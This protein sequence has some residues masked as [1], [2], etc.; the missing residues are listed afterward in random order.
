MESNDEAD[1]T[2]SAHLV[3]MVVRTLRHEVGDLLQSVYSAV[4][5]L[6]ERLPKGQSLERTI[7]ADLRG[8]AEMCKNELDATHDLVCPVSLNLDWVELSEV[9]AGI[10]AAFALRFPGLQIVCHAPRPVKVWADG[11]RLQQA[12]TLLMMAFCQAAHAKVEIRVVV[13]STHAAVEW[14]FSHDGPAATDEQL[15]WLAAPFSTTRQARF[16]LG[17]GL[18]RRIVELQGG[19]VTTAEVPEGGFRLILRLPSA[20]AVNTRENRD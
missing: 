19:C 12:G 5:L 9:A 10:A 1:R 15:S 16:G 3:E 8:R 4:A 18:A 6:Q 7:L 14:S 20:P 13:L 11:Q 17:L 2:P